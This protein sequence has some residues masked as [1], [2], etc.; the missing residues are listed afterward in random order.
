MRE[1]NALQSV[2]ALGRAI[3]EGDLQSAS[4]NCRRLQAEL[5][6]LNES[7]LIAVKQQL[8]RWRKQAY[9]LRDA[10]ST[11]LRRTVR[12]RRKVSAYR[13]GSALDRG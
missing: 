8:L 2:D 12:G 6:A 3:D 10:C 4:E 9:E 11:E 5:S 7:E 13:D 1:R